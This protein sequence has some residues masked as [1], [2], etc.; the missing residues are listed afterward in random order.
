MRSICLDAQHQGMIDPCGNIAASRLRRRWNHAI[1][2]SRGSG[3]WKWKLNSRDSVMADVRRTSMIIPRGKVKPSM[4][5]N[6]SLSVSALV[7][8]VGLMGCSDRRTSDALKEDTSVPSS[9][10]SIERDVSMVSLDE[11]TIVF[12]DHEFSTSDG[13]RKLADYLGE[14]DRT[15]ATD[16]EETWIWDRNGISARGTAERIEAVVVAFDPPGLRRG[17]P[18]SS[19][20]GTVIVQGRGNLPAVTIDAGSDKDLVARV[21]QL[22]R[23]FDSTH[24][25]ASGSL[26][27]IQADFLTPEELS[28]LNESP[29]LRS[30]YGDEQLR[31]PEPP[32]GSN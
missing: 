9:T 13:L 14:P 1:N 30:K 20:Q 26:I 31:E 18:R 11:S 12:D 32:S 17:S 3:G 19:F 21:R 24:D 4:S 16:S 29:L 22:H 23:G 25:A 5:V 10:K 28:K 7:L 15:L 6:S 2:R 27:D 8:A